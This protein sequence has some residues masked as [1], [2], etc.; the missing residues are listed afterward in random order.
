MSLS[1][2]IKCNVSSLNKKELDYN[3]QKKS[4]A[5]NIIISCD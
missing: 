4:G 3:L 1:L 5:T 2:I